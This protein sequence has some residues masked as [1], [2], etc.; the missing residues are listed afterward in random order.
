MRLAGLVARRAGAELGLASLD[1]A[2]RRRRHLGHD[3]ATAYLD[4]DRIGLGHPNRYRSATA[5][6]EQRR[7][8]R[9]RR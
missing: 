9:R 4:D 8:R 6:R 3:E 2:P 1:L 7:Q 5:D